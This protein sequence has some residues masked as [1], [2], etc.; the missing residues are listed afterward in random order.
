M[1]REI[2]LIYWY[3]AVALGRG[4]G[5]AVAAFPGHDRDSL[6]KGVRRDIP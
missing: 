4:K 6:G 5:I 2:M 1:P 3:D